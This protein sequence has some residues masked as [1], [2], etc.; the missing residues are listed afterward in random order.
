M[1]QPANGLTPPLATVIGPRKNPPLANA[2]DGP[3]ISV[4]TAT[5]TSP[6]RAMRIPLPSCCSGQERPDVPAQVPE[7]YESGLLIST[8]NNVPR[9]TAL[10]GGIRRRCRLRAA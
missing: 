1:V 10:A 5:T 9:G 6:A 7:A 4:A 3:A 2:A 8:P